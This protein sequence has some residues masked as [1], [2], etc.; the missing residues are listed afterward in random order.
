MFPI[1]LFFIILSI[2]SHRRVPWSKC[3]PSCLVA[4]LWDKSNLLTLNSN[5][6]TKTAA[7]GSWSCRESSPKLK[8]FVFFPMCLC[9]NDIDLRSVLFLFFEVIWTY[10]YEPIYMGQIGKTEPH[11]LIWSDLTNIS[12]QTETKILITIITPS[13]INQGDK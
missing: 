8:L 12:T 6:H 1:A 5:S 11:P 13:T 7:I 3:K 9:Q 2:A 10:L 4:Q